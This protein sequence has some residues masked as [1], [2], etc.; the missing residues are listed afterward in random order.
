MSGPWKPIAALGD[1]LTI[2]AVAPFI[3]GMGWLLITT[4]VGTASP[5]MVE[6]AVRLGVGAMMALVPLSAGGVFLFAF[7]EFAEAQA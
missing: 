6:Q 3:L 7:F 4:D 5:E 2:L 1:I